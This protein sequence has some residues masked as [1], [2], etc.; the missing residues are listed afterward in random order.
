M[1]REQGHYWYIFTF[2]LMD[3]HLHELE[4]LVLFLLFHIPIQKSNLLY[5]VEGTPQGCMCSPEAILMT[6]NACQSV[7]FTVSRAGRI[8]PREL[9]IHFLSVPLLQSCEIL[10]LVLHRLYFEYPLNFEGAILAAHRCAGDPQRP[11]SDGHD[12][13]RS[14]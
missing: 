8:V 1:P 12:D 14:D 2:H 3:L 4:A 10:D 5:R 9:A 13:V 7:Y 11:G 6:L